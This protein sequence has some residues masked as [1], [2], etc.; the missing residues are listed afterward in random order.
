MKYRR[1]PIEVESPEEYGYGKIRCN[2]TESSVADLRLEALDLDLNSLTLAYTDHAGK[3]ELRE[4]IAAE[5]AG[6]QAQDVLVTAGAAAALFIIATSLLDA[7]S[8]I[9]VMRPNYATNIETPRAIQCSID[10]LDLRFEHG[11]HFS[12]DRLAE[13]IQ[14]GT[15]LISL[16]TP[17]NPTG[18]TLSEADLRAAIALAEQ[19]D[20]YLLV[21]ETYGQMNFAGPTPLAAALSERCI[22]VASLSKSY[23]LPG[24]RMGWIISRD[25]RLRELFLAAKEQMYICNSI[26]DE[27]IAYRALAQKDRL[28]PPILEHN[29]AAFARMKAWME[30]QEEMEWVEPGGG[31][32]CFPRIKP[33]SR[34]DVETFYHILNEKYATFVGPGHWFEQERRSMRI[35]YGWPKTAELE[36]GLQN[37]ALALEEAKI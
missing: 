32:V 16:T 34:V 19:H 9:V 27:E 22:S 12:I 20:C 18:V 17:H 4:L 1:M 15:R 33:G 21:D 11:Y 6:L 8:R 10:F 5:G 3:P 25:R 35:G 23:G 24:I 31:V 28:L 29:R 14:P 36:E 2:L 26:V 30:R 7:S 37:V 13:V